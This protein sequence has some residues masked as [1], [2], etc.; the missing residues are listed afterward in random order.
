MLWRVRAYWSPGLPRPTTI[1]TSP[2]LEA[3]RGV[4]RATATTASRAAR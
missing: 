1:F 2:P 4:A 3:R